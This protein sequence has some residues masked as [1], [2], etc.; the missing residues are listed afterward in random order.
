MGTG[1]VGMGTGTST[2]M[3]LRVLVLFLLHIHHW[4]S[5]CPRYQYST[6]NSMDIS[7]GTFPHMERVL[8][9]VLACTDG[10]TSTCIGS[11][12]EMSTSAEPVPYW[13]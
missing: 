6:N 5:Y 1:T 10:D 8:V 13:Y 12:T 9:Q 2:G 11:I 3:V 7:K 4:Y